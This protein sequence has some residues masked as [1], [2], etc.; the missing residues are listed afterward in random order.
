MIIELQTP[1]KSPLTTELSTLGPIFE[2]RRQ[3]YQNNA[4]V[5]KKNLVENGLHPTYNAILE[6]R[7]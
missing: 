3:N 5:E 7:V 6:L 4:L 1:F 2:I